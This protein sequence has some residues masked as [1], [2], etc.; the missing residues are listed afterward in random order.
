[1]QINTSNKNVNT[2]N[3]KN[4]K[5]C[6]PNLFRFKCNQINMTDLLFI[7]GGGFIGSNIVSFFDSSKFRVHVLEPEFANISRL[8]NLDVITHRCALSDTEKIKQIIENNDICTII[9]LVSTLIP[10]STYEDYKNEFKNVIF[11]SIELMEICANR[12]VKFVYFSSG[13]TI[14]GNRNDMKPF[15]EDDDMSPISYY[16]WSKQMMENSILF[17]HRTA[18]LKYLI[19]RPSNPYGHGQNIHAKQGLVAVAIGKII[20]KLP[21]EVWGD[22]S[23]IRDYIYI[24]DLAKI[25]CMLIERDISNVTL[26]L[27][28]GRGYSVNDVLA[29]LK[30]V[31]GIDY[32][33]EYNNPRPVDVSNMVLDVENLKKYVDI[34]FTSFMDG[35]KIFFDEEKS[36]YDIK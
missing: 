4:E 30:I 28:S 1:M 14:Y 10:G 13:G 17:K 26:N 3:I 36:K 9:H 34:E 24:D 6:N 35:V 11:P 27:G 25:F 19:V 31:S 2:L 12:K 5:I 33:I 7:G 20:D 22:G 8:D 21:V 16:G 23:A 18:G 15:N 32:K 29:F